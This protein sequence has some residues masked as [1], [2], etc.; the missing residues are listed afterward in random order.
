MERLS[1]SPKSLTGT[2]PTMTFAGLVDYRA[3]NPEEF[4][5]EERAEYAKLWNPGEIPAK[6]PRCAR[7]I[8]TPAGMRNL[9]AAL[10]QRG[11]SENEIR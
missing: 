10:F 7:G 9:T 1:R 4:S 11:F 5:A 8:E 6:P 3:G 2:I